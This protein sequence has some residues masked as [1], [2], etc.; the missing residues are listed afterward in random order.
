MRLSAKNVS[1]AVVVMADTVRP[2]RMNI[3]GNYLR[4]DADEAITLATLLAD[5]A[6][7]L[8][9]RDRSHTHE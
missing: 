6:D 3:G 7:Q 4:M 2:I 9:T 5:A 8:R 1:P